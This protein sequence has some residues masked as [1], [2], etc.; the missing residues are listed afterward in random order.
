[1][2]VESF[3]ELKTPAVAARVAEQPEPAVL[4]GN[5]DR[6][7]ASVQV[8]AA[9]ANA[10]SGVPGPLAGGD[11]FPAVADIDPADGEDALYEDSLFL[12]TALEVWRCSW[13]AEELRATASRAQ[14]ARLGKIDET[15]Q[16]LG[17]KAADQLMADRDEVAAGRYASGL[18]TL[19]DYEEELERSCG[20]YGVGS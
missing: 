18:A 14:L 16:G 17:Q 3:A 4:M 2:V 6:A 12:Y 10:I 19:V 5:G 1:M 8:E 15:L 11:E 9:W 7:I 20:V 13:I